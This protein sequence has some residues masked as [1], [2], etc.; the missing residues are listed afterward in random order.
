M[1]QIIII[2]RNGNYPT[3]EELPELYDIP[4][5]S[6]PYSEAMMRALAGKNKG[7]PRI[8]SLPE[9]TRIS[10]LSAPYPEAIMRCLGREI[11]E[12]Y[13]CIVSVEGV[14]RE[15]VSNLFFG[16]SPIEA[17]YYNGQLVPSAY[18]GGRLVYGVRYVKK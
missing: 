13:P 6:A 18:C 10:D 5:K 11:N 4:D 7:Y 17:M 14:G 12:G 9:L 1:G 2:G 3:T 15:V 8:V 16:E